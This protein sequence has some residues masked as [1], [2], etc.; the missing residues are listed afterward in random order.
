MQGTNNESVVFPPFLK[1]K[2]V[3][4]AGTWRFQGENNQNS[5]KRHSHLGSISYLNYGSLRM[6]HL[7]YLIPAYGEV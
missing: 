6:K 1:A 5:N 3:F 2:G 7:I 4:N